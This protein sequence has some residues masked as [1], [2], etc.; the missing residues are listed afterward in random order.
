MLI[1]KNVL[2]HGSGFDCS[3]DIE[4]KKNGNV[5]AISS[6]HCMNENGYYD[7]FA[8][9]TV[10]FKKG[11]PI[12]DFVLQFNGKIAQR[13]NNKYFLREYLEESIYE[14]LR[15]YNDDIDSILIED[16]ILED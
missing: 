2:P 1:L 7:G 8:D 16:V 4:Q 6:F 14:S 12:A 10:I 9:F 3:W 5:Y 13:K 11:Q 15:Q